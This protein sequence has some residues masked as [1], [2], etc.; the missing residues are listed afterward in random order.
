M[1]YRQYV[2]EHWPVCIGK[3]YIGGVCGCPFLYFDIPEG[4]NPRRTCQQCWN[5]TLKPGTPV[6]DSPKVEA[7]YDGTK[8]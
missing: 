5:R 6:K 4:C 2:K 8:I 3:Q 1:T 7:L